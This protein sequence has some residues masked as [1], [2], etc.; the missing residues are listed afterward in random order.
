M[1]ER[2]GA[3]VIGIN[4]YTHNTMLTNAANDGREMARK[5]EAL[6]YDVVCLIDDNPSFNSFCTINP[7]R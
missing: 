3:I 5:L 4:Q 6:K 1:N 7:L 2:Y